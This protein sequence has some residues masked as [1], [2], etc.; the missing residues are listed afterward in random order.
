MFLDQLVKQERN[1]QPQSPGRSIR[2]MHSVA[3]ELSNEAHR[4]RPELHDPS[5]AATKRHRP[6]VAAACF[7]VGGD[8]GRHPDE[9]AFF[10]VI[11]DEILHQELIHRRTA[12]CPAS[13]VPETYLLLWAT[14]RPVQL[15]RSTFPAS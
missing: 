11:F 1:M 14:G 13:P 8:D 4:L 2:G 9:P 7:P 12:L 3:V 5:D 6:H 15:P 10:Q